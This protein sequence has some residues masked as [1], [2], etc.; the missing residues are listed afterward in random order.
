[1]TLI[2]CKPIS[3]SPLATTSARRLLS[4]Y[5]TQVELL[6]RAPVRAP[7]ARQRH[8]EQPDAVGWWKHLPHEA[9]AH[10]AQAF[11]RRD[12][13]RQGSAARDL[14]EVGILDL[15][16]HCAAEGLCLLAPGPDL[17]CHRQHA[18]L[19][20]GRIGQVVGKGRFRSGGFAWA[21]RHDRTI[22]LAIGNGVVPRAG[23]DEM[24]LQ[25]F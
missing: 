10:V 22:V 25:K 19:D 16:G 3:A 2:Y 13:R 24:L 4:P 18:G 11:L 15:Y 1:M 9:D 12:D 23:L 8:A 17:V 20:G 21:V 6:R 7:K 14:P 5:Q